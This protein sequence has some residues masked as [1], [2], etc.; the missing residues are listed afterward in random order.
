MTALAENLTF[1][2]RGGESWRDPWPA[3]RH[4]RDEDPVHLTQWGEARF[5]VLSRFEDVYRAARDTATFSSAQGLVPDA[6]AMDMFEGVAAPLVMLDPPDHTT[7]RRLVSRQMTPRRVA[8]IEGEI[9]E[10]V[11]RCLDQVADSSDVDIVAALFKPL[12]SFVVSHYLGVPETDRQRFDTWTQAIVAANSDSGLT[13]ADAAG[14][15]FA[16]AI[17]LIERRR[18]DPG[19]DMVSDLTALGEETVSAAW[20]IG[21]VFTMVAGGNDTTSGLLGGAAELLTANP[22][23]RRILIDDPERI[24]GAVEE[25]LRLSSPVQNLARTTTRPFE[26]HGRTI[27][28]GDKVMLVYGS[29]NR[30]EREF[31]PSAED[32]DLDRPIERTLAFGSGAHHCLGAAVARIQGRVVLSRLL[33]RFPHFTVDAAAGTYSSGP[34]VRRFESLPFHATAGPAGSS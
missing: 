8:E 29:A 23:Q 17:D 13:N 24:A 1:P 14:E 34:Y 2:A 3:Y 7:M 5:W 10:F 6:N 22:Q 15:M 11:D 27:P 21:F 26:L 31:G 9:T 20:I 28:E 18:R 32:L 33:E 12:P 4:L 19:P 25:F 30:D 16:Y